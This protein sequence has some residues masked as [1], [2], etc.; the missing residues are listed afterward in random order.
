MQFVT[1]ILWTEAVDKIGGKTPIGS[2]LDSQQ[3]R[4]VPLALRERAFFSSQIESVRFLQ[5]SRD[6]IKDYLAQTIETLPDGRT[7]IKAGGRQ[8]FIRDMSEFAISEGMGPLDTADAGTIKDIRSEGRLGLIFDTMTQSANDYTFWKQGMDPDVLDAFPAQQF[9]RER[10]VKQ[11][12]PVHQANE[13]VIRLKSDLPFWLGMNDPSF[14]GF[15]VPWGPWGF[16]SGMGVDDVDRETTEKLGMIKPGEKPQPVDK[17]FNEHLEASTRGLDDDMVGKLKD[18]FGDQ[19]EFDGDNVQWSGR[20]PGERTVSGPSEEETPKPDSQSEAQTLPEILSDLGLDA[21]RAA[22]ADDMVALREQLQESNPVKADRI[23]KYIRGAQPSG[24]VTDGKIQSVVQEFINYLPA[25]TLQHL[26][27]LQI[28]VLKGGNFLGQYGMRGGL[29]L[30]GALLRYDDERTRRTIF[31]ELMH[32]VHREGSQE[33]R[34]AIRRHFE[35]RTAGEKIRRLPGYGPGVRGKT[36]KW[37]ET[38]AG[39]IYNFEFKPDGLEV[40]TKYIEW[41]T[42]HPDVMAKLWNEPDFR[43][44]MKLVLTGLF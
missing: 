29:E 4:D 9:I 20:D 7:A 34:D 33:Y 27:P 12:R 25:S 32:W 37:Y 2:A 40:P 28:D 11:P 24:A 3:W 6:F 31:H 39:R 36:D 5:R 42:M 21:G 8:Q 41:L 26:P 19:V 23:I 43:E 10:D 18:A 16:S 30:N 22:T 35:E 1:P 38:Y 44:T 14:G 13:G 15:G 17:D